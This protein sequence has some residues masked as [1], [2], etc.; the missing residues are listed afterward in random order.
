[1]NQLSLYHRE[2][3]PFGFNSILILF[4][5]PT[6]IDFKSTFISVGENKV[7]LALWDT[8]GAERFR[9]LTPSFYRGAQGAILVYD[10]T[11]RDTLQKLDSWFNE[12]DVYSTRENLVKMVVGNKVDKENRAITREEGLRWARRHSS[13]FIEASARTKEGVKTAFEELVEKILQTPG[14]WEEVGGKRNIRLEEPEAQ[15][16]SWCSGYCF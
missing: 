9:S 14:L 7:K 2:G 12:L 3:Y 1:M 6:G 11:R 13:L 5:H 16:K 15:E 8:A 4:S 10:V